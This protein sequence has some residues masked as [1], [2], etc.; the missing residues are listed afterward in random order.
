METV[1][2][3]QSSNALTVPISYHTQQNCQQ[4]F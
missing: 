2:L 3:K 1:S 4:K